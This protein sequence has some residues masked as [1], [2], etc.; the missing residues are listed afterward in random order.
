MRRFIAALVLLPLLAGCGDD[1]GGST[2]RPAAAEPE[3]V[4]TLVLTSA[5]GEVAPTAYLVD[6]RAQ[7]K[8][9][10]KTFED[11]DDVA[12]AIQQ[13]VG[14]ADDR[15]G[16]LAVATIAIGCDVPEDVSI[17]EGEDGW[18]VHPGKVPDPKQ[19]CFAPTTSVALVELP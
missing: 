9:Y 4:Q 1:D 8:A 5:G 6:D 19:E 15:D 17:T 3:L 18:E 10:V 11:R 16:E 12:A 2:D 14:E 7:M 13:A